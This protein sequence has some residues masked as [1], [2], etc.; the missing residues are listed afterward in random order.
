MPP[1]I[2]VLLCYRGCYREQVVSLAGRLRDAGLKVTYDVEIL[3]DPHATELK[4]TNVVWFGLGGKSDD[5]GT[6]WRAP[7]RDAIVRADLSAF[8]YD[9]Q[10]P[11]E[12]VWNEVAWVSRSGRNVFF[13]IDT[14]RGATSEEHECILLGSLQSLYGMA[15]ETLTN[16]IPHFGYQFI[17]QDDPRALDKRIDV[18]ANR[19]LAYLDKVR[20]HGLPTLRLDN[21]LTLEKVRDQPLERARQ[22]LRSIQRRVGAL[23]LPAPRVAQIEA[24]GESVFRAILDQL[25]DREAGATVTNGRLRQ[26]D[27][28]FTYPEASERR[29]FLRTE[30]IAQRVRSGPFESSHY[31]AMLAREAATIEMFVEDA[32]W[33]RQPEAKG[34]SAAILPGTLPLSLSRSIPLTS[35]DKDSAVLLLNAAFLDLCYQIIKLSVGSWTNA[36]SSKMGSVG[37]AAHAVQTRER[38]KSSPQIVDTLINWLHG[39]CR[40]GYLEGHSVL[41]PVQQQLPLQLLTNY[42]ERFTLAHGYAELGQLDFLQ[43]GPPPDS[44]PPLFCDARATETVLATAAKFDAVDPTIALQGCLIAINADDMVRRALAQ[45]PNDGSFLLPEA[46]PVREQRIEVARQAHLKT[47]QADGVGEKDARQACAAA[48]EA[49]DTV[50]LLW[51]AAQAGF[52]ARIAPLERPCPMWLVP[53]RQ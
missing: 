20:R 24:G 6:R 4:D 1:E 11:S 28:P 39:Y 46:A 45:F 14:G 48:C 47:L 43:P 9:A 5:G 7:L 37:F 33:A 2:D 53:T 34:Y 49:A 36:K 8:L 12:N 19:I 35:C 22:R 51:E 52:V 21:D 38:I 40:L 25:H 15:R 44:R 10:S 30:G 29:R 3:S 27:S 32:L 16:E 31:F 26:K 42:A 17:A 13:V 18:L 50:L 23:G 41:P